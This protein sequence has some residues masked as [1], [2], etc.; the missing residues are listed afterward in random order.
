MQV[1]VGSLEASFEVYHGGAESLWHTCQRV[2][3]PEEEVAQTAAPTR[4]RML[5][6]ILANISWCGSFSGFFFQIFFFFFLNQQHVAACHVRFSLWRF[7]FTFPV[8]HRRLHRTA[9]SPLR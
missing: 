8:E 7:S 2:D 3:R 9:V 1:A 6:C 4:L 5:I